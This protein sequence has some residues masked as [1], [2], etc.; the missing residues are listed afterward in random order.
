MD[1]VRYHR[2]PTNWRTR[3][4]WTVLTVERA[5]LAEQ[6]AFDRRWRWGN[7]LF[8]DG[9]CVEVSEWAG[10][11]PADIAEIEGVIAGLTPALAP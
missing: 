9:K 3:S 11:S 8:V 10:H 1:T 2:I 7:S 5:D 6:L 4:T